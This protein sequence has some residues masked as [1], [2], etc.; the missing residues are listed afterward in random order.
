LSNA[1]LLSSVIIGGCREEIN[2]DKLAKVV[3]TELKDMA[4]DVDFAQLT[5]AQVADKVWQRLSPKQLATIEMT[6]KGEPDTDPKFFFAPFFKDSKN[7]GE[8]KEKC[9]SGPAGKAVNN[10]AAVKDEAKCNP[11]PVTLQHIIASIGRLQKRQGASD[12]ASN[13]AAS[14]TGTGAGCSVM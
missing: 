6:F 12:A 8:A 9:K 13:A 5:T 11:V 14:A 2:K 10:S 7:L 1:K 3:E 4:K